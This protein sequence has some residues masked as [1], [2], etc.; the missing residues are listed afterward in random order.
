M[1]TAAIIQQLNVAYGRLRR[2]ADD[3]TDEEARRVLA[4]TLLPVTW[5]IGHLAVVDT[6]FVNR[7]GGRHE[8]PGGYTE[9]FRPG[10]VGTAQYPPFPDVWAA[11]ETAHQALLRTAGGADLDAAAESSAGTY[12]NVGEMLIFACV[13]RG[14][15]IGKITSLRALLGKPVLFMPPA[16]R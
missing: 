8:C 13:H 5:Q 3:L 9:M 2:C 16:Q 12:T 7:A 1:D 15:H 10:S 14:Y 4:G 6:S 11:F